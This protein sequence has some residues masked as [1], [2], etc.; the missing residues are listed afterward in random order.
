[1][2]SKSLSSVLQEQVAAL[3]ETGLYRD[4]ESI[5]AD[6]VAALFAARPDLRI[7]VACRFYEKGRFSLGRAAEWSRLTIKGFKD[8]LHRKGIPRQTVDDPEVIE[9][10]ARAAAERAGRPEPSW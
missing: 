5:L 10:M 3:V 9:R 7:A 4:E 2:S 6:A 8:E 1:M